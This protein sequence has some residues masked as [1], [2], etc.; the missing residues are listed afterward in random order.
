MTMDFMETIEGY[1]NGKSSNSRGTYAPRINAFASFLREEKEIGD[2]NFKEYLTAINSDIIL[3][4]LNKYII[5]KSIRKETVA[6]FYATAVKDYFY[7]LNE[8]GIENEHLMKEF[9]Y[10][11][12]KSYE[13]KITEFV[14]NNP[15][16][17]KVESKSP[18]DFEDIKILIAAIDEKIEKA[19][20]NPIVITCDRDKYNPFNDL[21]Y[22][23]VL[24]IMIFAGTEYVG[25]RSLEEKCLDV[26][27]RKITI[28]TYT[29]HMPDNLGEQLIE[30]INI[31]SK[32]CMRSDKLFVLSG[33]KELI[34]QTRKLSELLDEIIGRKDTVGV[35]KYVIIEMIRKGINQSF[36]MKLTGV[37]TTIFE[38]C[39]RVVNEE[40]HV[41]ANRYID[42]KMR[43]M[44]VF[45]YL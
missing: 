45:D 35:R 37:G 32:R 4:A 15:N 17:E 20:C 16:L 14:E 3:E 19:I 7:Y 18:L 21:S 42:S 40:R 5:D 28:N 26:T 8:L 13:K 1:I 44:V 23:L 41:E 29:L 24:K 31:K 6:Y 10:K 11:N 12:N 22:F 25:L 33:N 39:Q 36:I 2:R 43:D 30:Y 38:D 9:A 34:L 27:R